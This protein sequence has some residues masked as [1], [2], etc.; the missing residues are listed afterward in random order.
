MIRRAR[1]ALIGVTLASTACL[2]EPNPDFIEPNGDAG[3][4][5]STDAGMCPEGTLDCDGEPGC[6]SDATDPSSCGSCSKVC[7]LGGQM[8]ECV[9][10]ECVGTV[11]F[12]ELAD[13][14]VDADQPSQ[15]FGLEPTLIVDASRATFIAL[16]DIGALPSGAIEHVGL[17]VTC[18]QL[19]TTLQLQRVETEW[20]EQQLTAS[21][22]PSGSEVIGSFDFTL[23][24][25]VVELAG[26][27]PSW[28]SGTPKRSIELSA[29]GPDP[30]PV[31]FSSREGASAPYLTVT[32]SW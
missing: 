28:R 12:T 3:E 18:T 16:P 29:T 13:T 32:L 7:E 24:E 19:G 23:G 6:E 9:E 17:H 31:E 11:T 15:N 22:A 21:S 26:M 4:T 14:Y 8:I 10:G 20:D 1:A 25:N 5:D 2:I 30:L 27:L